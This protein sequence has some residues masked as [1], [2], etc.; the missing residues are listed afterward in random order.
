MNV[1]ALA[2]EAAQRTVQSSQELPMETLGDL[3]DNVS[4]VEHWCFT[5]D[6]GNDALCATRKFCSLDDIH[7]KLASGHRF[8]LYKLY[9]LQKFGM[10]GEPPSIQPTGEN[11]YH[12][13]YCARA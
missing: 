10:Q 8:Y 1:I 2:W 3:G 6:D 9:E 11:F 4:L 12:L 13:R 5:D 7:R